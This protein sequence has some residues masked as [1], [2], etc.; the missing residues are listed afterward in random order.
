MN[1]ALQ[2]GTYPPWYD[3]SYWHE[4]IVAH[5]DLAGQIRVLKDGAQTLFE[6]FRRSGLV[7]G[8]LILYFVGGWKWSRVKDVARH[9]P[10]F[11]PAVVAFMIYLLTVVRARYLG[12][13]IVLLWMG[14]FSGIRLRESQDS[15]R[16]IGCATLA[17]VTVM[18]I[19]VSFMPVATALS[20][21]GQLVK[22][23]NPWP[24]VQYEVAEGLKSIGVEPGDKVA[25][26]G[27]SFKA[28]WARL[29]GVKIVAEIPSKEVANFW[30]ADD[31]IKSQVIKTFATT[32]A[33]VVVANKVPGIVSKGEWQRMGHTSYHVRILPAEGKEVVDP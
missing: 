26:I 27:T 11:A 18:M 5:F 30:A 31:S 33:R 1:L 25:S 12:A 24:H 16:L 4:G 32:G 29:A 23:S 10:L 7:V 14:I 3:P 2:L 17:M 28:Y 20:R 9:W 13:F 21:A 22:G 8:C 19:T 15:K 6:I